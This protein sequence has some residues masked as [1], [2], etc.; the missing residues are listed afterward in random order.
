MFEPAPPMHSNVTHDLV[1]HNVSVYRKEGTF[2]SVS[3]VVAPAEDDTIITNLGTPGPPLPEGTWSNDTHCDASTHT[4]RLQASTLRAYA[5]PTHDSGIRIHAAQRL[6]FRPGQLVAFAFVAVDRSA[7]WH[8]P[9]APRHRALRL[10]DPCGGAQVSSA[11]FENTTAVVVVEPAE[12][13][14]SHGK[15][16][17]ASNSLLRVCEREVGA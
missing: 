1:W 2:G 12:S 9:L 17:H 10:L 16:V 7:R 13:V 14:L 6:Y 5:P 8:G 15:S 4:S 3:V 11:Q